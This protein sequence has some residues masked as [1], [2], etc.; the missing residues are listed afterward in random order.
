[1]EVRL[2]STVMVVRALVAP[3][4]VVLVLGTVLSAIRTVILPRSAQSLLNR[5]VFRSLRHLFGAVAR[6]RSSFEWRDRV[7]ALFAPIGLLTLVA[8]WLSLVTVAFWWSMRTSPS[9]CQTWR[10]SSTLD[11]NVL[12]LIL[13]RDVSPGAEAFACEAAFC[14]A[15]TDC[16]ARARGGAPPARHIIMSAATAAVIAKT[17][18]NRLVSA[19]VRRPPSSRVLERQH[20]GSYE[21]GGVSQ[22]RRYH[23]H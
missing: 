19:G 21:R 14:C 20:R 15:E 6:L 1:M 17:L 4:G 7:M 2:L 22:L 12:N 16:R 10:P 13:Y 23:P 9:M 8:A 11:L 5:V 18:F 3:A